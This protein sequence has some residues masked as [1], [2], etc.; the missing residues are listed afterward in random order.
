[1]DSEKKERLENKRG[2]IGYD[3]DG[4]LAFYDGWKGPEHIGEP[5]VPML[6]HL[7]RRLREGWEVR[8]FTARAFDPVQIPFVHDWLVKHGLPRLA[9]T[10]VK[11][12]AMVTLFDDRCKQVECNTGRIIGE[13]NHAGQ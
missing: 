9:V 7:K 13:D 8:I 12:F 2:W 3:L 4:T 10:N 6:E 5:I 11:D 1:M